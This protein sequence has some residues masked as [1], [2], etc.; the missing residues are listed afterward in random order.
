MKNIYKKIQNLLFRKIEFWIFALMIIFFII[1]TF[2]I[3]VLVRQGTE[4]RTSLGNFSI[5]FLTEPLVSI[6]RIPEKVIFKI[7][8]PVELRIG[9][10][11]D[12]KKSFTEKVGFTGSSSKNQ[13]LLLSRYSIKN[14]QSIV[15]LVDLENFNVIHTWKP[16]ID[17]FHEPV[18]KIGQ[19]KNLERDRNKKR[20]R[21]IHPIMTKDGGIIFSNFSQLI[22]VDHCSNLVWQNFE[23]V[24][25]HSKEKDLNGNY[26]VPINIFQSKIKNFESVPEHNAIV[27]VSPEGKILF[28]K[29]LY[30]L[31][32]E[33]KMEH[34]IHGIGLPTNDIFHLNDIEPAMFKSNYW[35][36][37]D[38]FLSLRNLSMIIQYR[39]STNKI[40][41]IIHGPFYNQ[42]D[43]DIINDKEISIFNN[44]YKSYSIGNSE[45]VIYNF[46][47][48]NFKKYLDNQIKK[49]KVRTSF[50]GLHSILPN[51]DLFLE[52]TTDGRILFFEGNGNLKWHFTNNENEDKVLYAINWSR[53]LYNTE[54][55]KKI[56]KL[57]N[58]LIEKKCK[59]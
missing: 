18:K 57:K 49:N 9:D 44:N 10:F 5:K 16:E 3:S 13:F 40:I 39:P 38:L 48:N 34:Y 15:E 31:F 4:G 59:N 25:H 54:Q 53:I 14:K 58:L 28:I 17:K 30:E 52:S 7:L 45:I 51:G 50:A 1:L 41:N 24:F 55:L 11:W 32:I 43:V 36:I 46:K 8:K 22:K 35:D 47:T 33:N 26:W 20:F 6:T 37:G 23:H 56:E 21:I 42:H 29:S 12:P 27:K 2:S 19:F